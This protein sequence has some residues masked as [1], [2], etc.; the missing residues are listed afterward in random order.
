MRGRATR[1]PIARKVANSQQ[2]NQACIDRRWK[3]SHV[4]YS[5]AV[6]VQLGLYLLWLRNELDSEA[7][8]LAPLHVCK[9]EVSAPVRNHAWRLGDAMDNAFA[10]NL[11]CG[12]LS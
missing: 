11:C 9:C 6:K 10:V 8:F 3:C 4:C 5:L 2:D 12:A 1:K 7:A